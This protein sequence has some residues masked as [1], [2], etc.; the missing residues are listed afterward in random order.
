MAE[1]AQKLDLSAETL[2]K[3]RPGQSGKTKSLPGY[4]RFN[5]PGILQA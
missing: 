5:A 1:R 3:G 4:G 2:E